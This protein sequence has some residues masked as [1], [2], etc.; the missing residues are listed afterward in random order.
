MILRPTRREQGESERAGHPA[1]YRYANLNSARAKLLDLRE[2]I[3]RIRTWDAD[4]SRAD[5]LAR[6]DAY[7][8][9]ARDTASA[10]AKRAVE[11]VAGRRS[12]WR[13]NWGIGCAVS[14]A[15][16]AAGISTMAPIFRLFGG[17]LEVCVLFVGVTAIFAPGFWS[18]GC[19]HPPNWEDLREAAGLT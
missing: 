10:Q 3:A 8:V 6:V 18:N 14:I 11:G 7:I 19:Q 2:E 5:T 17:C 13:R 16:A 15:V 1:V 9:R 4:R 12:N